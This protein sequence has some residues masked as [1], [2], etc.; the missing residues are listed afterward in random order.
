MIFNNEYALFEFE[1]CTKL[2]CPKA[3]DCIDRRRTSSDDRSILK[4]SDY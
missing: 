1:R 4:P 3:S 2:F